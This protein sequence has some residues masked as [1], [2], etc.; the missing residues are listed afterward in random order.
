[1]RLIIQNDVRALMHEA[2]VDAGRREIGGILMGEDLGNST[3]RVKEIT[4]QKHGGSFSAFVRALKDFLTPLQR[5]F[6]N[7]GHDYRRFNYLGEWH[8]HHSFALIPSMEDHHSM[9][10]IVEDDSVGANF[11]VLLLVK[12]ADNDEVDAAVFVYVRGETLAIGEV[13][14]EVTATP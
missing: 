10:E 13:L 14:W 12:L 3:F 4:V 7:T 1:M 5:Y 11:V 9:F 8:S 6:R 2:L